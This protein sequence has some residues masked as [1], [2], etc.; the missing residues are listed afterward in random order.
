M[1][2]TYVLAWKM[3]VLLACQMNFGGEMKEKEITERRSSIPQNLL[4]L[5]EIGVMEITTLATLRETTTGEG[6]K[7]KSSLS[8]TG[9]TYCRS[10][11]QYI[12]SREA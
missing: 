3:L 8:S 4:W 10:L 1:I 2:Q 5:W 7:N 11:D 12:P 9:L 6:E